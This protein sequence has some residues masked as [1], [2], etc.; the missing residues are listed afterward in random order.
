MIFHH[1]HETNAAGQIVPAKPLQAP[2]IGVS[3]MPGAITILVLALLIMRGRRTQ[4][5]KDARREESK[6]ATVA[7]L[8]PVKT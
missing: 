8:V 1:H 7:D 6:P 2:E 5:K 3:G 4:A